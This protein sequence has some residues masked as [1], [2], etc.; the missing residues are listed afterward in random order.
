M[1]LFHEVFVVL[2]RFC[3]DTVWVAPE[4][5]VIGEEKRYFQA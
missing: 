2:K 4:E 3:P 5:L 1:I